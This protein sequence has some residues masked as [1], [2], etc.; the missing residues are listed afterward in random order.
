MRHR[1]QR[2]LAIL[3][4]AR[5]HTRL[6][7]RKGQHLADM[8]V[9]IGDQD[10]FGHRAVVPAPPRASIAFIVCAFFITLTN[11][12]QFAVA[13]NIIALGYRQLF[14]QFAWQ[15]RPTAAHRASASR[16]FCLL[17]R[18]VPAPV[19]APGSR[20]GEIGVRSRRCS[21]LASGSKRRTIQIVEIAQVQMTPSPPTSRAWRTFQRAAISPRSTKVQADSTANAASTLPLTSQARLLPRSIRQV[22]STSPV[23]TSA[24]HSRA[25]MR[26]RVSE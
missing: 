18:S 11:R 12:Q 13:G 8:R 7:Q 2:R 15:A 10:G 19:G 6:F 25:A 4:R 24:I 20:A 17:R 23:A 14:G 5:A 3:R 9:V 21:R 26:N 1:R 22:T 16:L